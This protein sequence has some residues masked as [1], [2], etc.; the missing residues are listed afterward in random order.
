MRQKQY[1]VSEDWEGEIYCV[2]TLECYYKKVTLYPSMPLYVEVVFHT[3]L[4]KKTRSNFAPHQWNRL[5]Y[6]LR[7]Q[8]ATED[9]M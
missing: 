7:V 4:H 2:I 6:G 5:D 9:N 8:K 1:E 3:Y